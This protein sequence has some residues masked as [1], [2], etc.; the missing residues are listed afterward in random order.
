[1]GGKEAIRGFL[2]QGFASVLEALT[3]E[4]WNKIYVEYPTEYDKV[5]IALESDGKIVKSIQVKS[6]INLFSKSNIAKWI[7]DLTNDVKAS[8]YQ[9]VLIG[10]CDKDANDFVNSIDK[11]RNGIEDQKSK[12]ALKGFD[13]AILDNHNISIKTL[14]LEESSLQSIVRD[15]LN[16]FVSYKGYTIPFDCLELIAESTVSTQMLL[17]RNERK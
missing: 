13:N 5:D 8:E 7:K 2:Y 3:Q 6:S 9:I 11:Y 16:K 1:M 14:P 15:A 17:A 10:S 4:F 12:D